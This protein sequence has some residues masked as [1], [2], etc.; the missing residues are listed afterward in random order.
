MPLVAS[1]NP[2]LATDC[3]LQECCSINGHGV[4][5]AAANHMFFVSRGDDCKSSSNNN[6]NNLNTSPRK[7]HMP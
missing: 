5:I 6:T 7:T 4:L 1:E 3:C 2:T